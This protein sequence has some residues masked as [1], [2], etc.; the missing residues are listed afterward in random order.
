MNKWYEGIDINLKRLEEG[1]YALRPIEWVADR[2]A[3]CWKWRKITEEEMNELTERVIRY[4]ERN[5][6]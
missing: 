5:K 1:R 4:N 2:I 3:W 6:V